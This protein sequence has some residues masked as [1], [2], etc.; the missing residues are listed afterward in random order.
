MIFSKIGTDEIQVKDE[1]I[2]LRLFIIFL[3]FFTSDAVHET[4]QQSQ[5]T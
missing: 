5:K 1:V 2:V 3:I 4:D